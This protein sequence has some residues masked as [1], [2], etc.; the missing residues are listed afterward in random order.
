MHFLESYATS[1]GL[2]IKKTEPTTQYYPLP[3]EK[4]IT[5]NFSSSNMPAKLYDYAQELVNTVK[6]ELDKAGITILQMGDAQ[7]VG[8]GGTY[9]LAGQTTPA[10]TAHI[11]KNAL[12]HLGTDSFLIHLASVF[13]TPILGLYSVSSP[14][15]CGPYWNKE[16]AIC[17][18]PNF[19]PNTTYS[20]NPGESPKMINTIKIEQIVEALGGL[21]NINFP[22]F[23]TH[24]IGELFNMPLLDSVPNAVVRPDFLPNNGI[25]VRLDKG[26]SVELAI[27]QLKYRRCIL[28]TNKPVDIKALAALR[29]N[30]ERITY[31]IDENYSLEFC[32]AA[33]AAGLPLELISY[34]DEAWLNGIKLDF[35]DLPLVNR[36]LSRT[37][38]EG[39]PE[40][41]KFRTN[42][43]ILSGGKFYLSYAHLENGISVPSLDHSEGLVVDSAT[44]W[45]DSGFSWIF[46]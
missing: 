32:K 40:S 4:Y 19:P 27:E 7:E 9:R 12:A 20:V 6:P 31:E 21:L 30:I 26:G 8:L 22:K 36:V 24:H 18:E 13:G 34:K 11:V 2:R 14:K 1:C 45:N 46:S 44:F 5:A 38:P 35:L 43:R 37:R 41:S 33:I 42:K 3:F 28:V 10:Q 17:L 39:I 25:Y 16:K 29:Q 15:V 23:T